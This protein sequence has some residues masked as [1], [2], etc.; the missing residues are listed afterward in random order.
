[1]GLTPLTRRIALCGLLSLA[2]YALY[3]NKTEIVTT[4]LVSIGFI[5]NPEK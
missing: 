4:C 1:M 2:F 5:I 3:L